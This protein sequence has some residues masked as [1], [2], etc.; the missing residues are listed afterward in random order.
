MMEMEGSDECFYSLVS[1]DT[2]Y[3]KSSPQSNK[4]KNNGNQIV[5]EVAALS[6]GDHSRFES[7]SLW[8]QDF[9]KRSQ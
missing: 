4:V 1:S 7:T 6:D 3:S 8:L 2:N 5:P 9:L